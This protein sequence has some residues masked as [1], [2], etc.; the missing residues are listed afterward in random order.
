MEAFLRP[1]T[2]SFVAIMLLAQVLGL[3]LMCVCGHCD[4]SR[5]W[6]SA[7]GI[8]A[9]DLTAKTEESPC[10]RAAR[11]EAEANAAAEGHSV[12][13]SEETPALQGAS[14]PCSCNQH[15][16]AHLDSE[17][18]GPQAAPVSPIALVLAAES[19][20]WAAL[21][22]HPIQRRRLPQAHAPP[23]LGALPH[24]LLHSALLI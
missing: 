11:L 6:L 13:A 24:Y 5:A 18:T 22:I 17:P 7:F 20:P 1:W 10:C 16:I 12:A 14:A 23:G 2:A 3:Q 8:A 9:T 4:L 15:S 21:A 19:L